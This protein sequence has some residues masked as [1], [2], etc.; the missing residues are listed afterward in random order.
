MGDLKISSASKSNMEDN[1][2]DV[3]LG[4]AVL[5][6]PTQL[7]ETEW[8]NSNFG[9]Q[10][11]IYK[12]IPEFKIGLDMRAIW[13]I[14]NKIEADPE[15]TVI[16]DH[17]SG[18]GKDTF[19]NILKNMLIVKRLAGDSYAEIVKDKPSG[20]LI[21]LKPLN[22]GRMKDIYNAQGILIRHE[23][24]MLNGKVQTFKPSQIFHLTNKRICDEI[25][26]V[27]DSEALDT[28][29]KANKES[30]DDV[31]KLM[32]RFVK[33][34][35]HVVLD[36]DDP[37]KIDDFITRFDAIVNKGENLFTPKGTVEKVDIIAIPPNA[38]L[39]S[40]P[41]REHLKN[42]FFQTV[43]MPQ[44]VLGSSGEF[45]ES[46]AKIAYLAFENSVKDEQT[47][48]IEQVWDQLFLKIKLTFPA[49]LKNELLSDE[50]KDSTN[51]ATKPSDT[52]AGEGA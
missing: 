20:K 36:V 50:A 4:I 13:T 32:H 2:E 46:T 38:T 10:L 8:Q 30:F 14:G 37:A 47:D 6:S 7:K 31:R 43:G 22:A 23:Y 39:N 12:T 15:T 45:T 40:L 19:R 49:S 11:S 5:D 18:W 28:I 29:I 26:G 16:L 35:L 24:D 44:I 27:A 42:Y 25:H 52:I 3:D 1:V 48:I 17:L 9:E 34:M 41:W 51:G 21:N 33:P